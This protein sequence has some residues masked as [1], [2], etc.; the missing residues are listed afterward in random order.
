MMPFL[1]SEVS[2]ITTQPG[3]A[4]VMLPVVDVTKLVDSINEQKRKNEQK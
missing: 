3:I 1:R 2:L 4:P